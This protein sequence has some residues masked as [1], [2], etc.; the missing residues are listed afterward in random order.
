MTGK[1]SV[2]GPPSLSI[3]RCVPT[4]KGQ[5]YRRKCEHGEA[6]ELTWNR[7]KRSF[8]VKPFQWTPFG[9]VRQF[10]NG[11]N[12]FRL[13]TNEKREMYSRE[14]AQQFIFFWYT[15]STPLSFSLD[16]GGG[17]IGTFI[18]ESLT[19]STFWK[20]GGNQRHNCRSI[21]PAKNDNF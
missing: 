8:L 16:W 7:N 11:P 10:S 5:S 19:I 17:K 4:E 12:L 13:A 18:N 14:K 6:A 1:K 15:V 2:K 20:T 9:H 3:G 21:L